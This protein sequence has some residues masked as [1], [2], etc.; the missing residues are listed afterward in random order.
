MSKRKQKRPK[1]WRNDPQQ[2]DAWLYKASDQMRAENY[3]GVIRTC[4]RVIRYIPRRDKVRAETFS[5]IGTAHA[6]Q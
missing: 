5:L 3:E 4:K 1:S 2:V 6:M